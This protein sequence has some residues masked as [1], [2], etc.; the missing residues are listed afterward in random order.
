M[1]VEQYNTV[2]TL[3]YRIIIINIVPEGCF[4]YLAFWW[5]IFP[6]HARYF[7]IWISIVLIPGL[8]PTY[9]SFLYFTTC[10]LICRYICYLKYV[11]ASS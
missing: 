9:I 4:L 11:S 1:F 3:Y 6:S 5:S 7:I 10:F 2:K 8:R